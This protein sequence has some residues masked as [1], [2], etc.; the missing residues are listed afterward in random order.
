MITAESNYPA[1]V[2]EIVAEHTVI[3]MNW[4]LCSNVVVVF[5]AS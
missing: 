4:I 5:F 1:R 3:A 2:S